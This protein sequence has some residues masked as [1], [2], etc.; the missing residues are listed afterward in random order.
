[1]VSDRRL[2]KIVD[3]FCSRVYRRAAGIVVLSIGI[4]EKL[5]TRGVAME[6]IEVVY[7]WCDEDAMTIHTA[8]DRQQFGMD[9]RFNV[10]FAGTMGRAQALDAVVEAARLVGDVDSRVQFIFVG[11]G[12]DRTRLEQLAAKVAPANTK[13]LS[14]MPMNRI[15]QVLGAADALLVHL[16]D[17]V[18]FQ[19]TI[20]S[21]TQAY[22]AAGKPIIMAVRGDA[23]RL[24]EDAQAGVCTIPENPIALMEAVLRLVHMPPEELEQMGQRGRTYYRTRL[25][26]DVG[27][28]KFIK[29]FERAKGV[30]SH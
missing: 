18:L 13:F 12:V 28:K 26:L 10:L 19:I 8:I 29:V 24:I 16:R 30:R 7:N 27:V 5:V 21:K 25:S 20:P 14:R 9:G 3:W 1:M 15:G 4:R 6:K 22:M 17:D 11:G 2:L 23:A